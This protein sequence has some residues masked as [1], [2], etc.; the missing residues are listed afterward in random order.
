MKLVFLSVFLLLASS[1][2]SSSAWDNEDLEVFDLVELINQN[3]YE[4]MGIKQV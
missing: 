2:P 1:F 3:F 4:L